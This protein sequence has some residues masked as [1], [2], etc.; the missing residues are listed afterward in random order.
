MKKFP[1]GPC[2]PLAN[3]RIFFGEIQW[4]FGANERASR[5]VTARR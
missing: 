1:A 4:R 3:R 2:T 5:A